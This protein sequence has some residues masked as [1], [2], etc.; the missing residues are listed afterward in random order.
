MLSEEKQKMVHFLIKFLDRYT[1]SN[2]YI[3]KESNVEITD[4]LIEAMENASKYEHMLDMVMNLLVLWTV[5]LII[6]TIYILYRK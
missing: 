1:L 5:I 3:F 2:T 4:T 6:Y